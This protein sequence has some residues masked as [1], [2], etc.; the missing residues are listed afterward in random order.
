MGFGFVEV[1]TIT[2]QPQ[3]GNPK[4]RVFRLPA[5]HALINRMGFNN[6]GVASAVH[7]F[8]RRNRLRP[9]RRSVILGVNLG[10]NTLTP[11]EKAAADY[12][13]LFRSLYEYVNYFVINVSC[14][15]IANLACLQNKDNLKELLQGLID[16]RRGQIQYRPIL[17]KI[18]PDLSQEQ[19][20]EMIEVLI[21]NGLDGIV[22]T[23]TTTRRDGLQT[24]ADLVAEIGKGGMSGGPLTKRSLEMVRYIHEKTEGRFPI[25]GVGGIMTEDDAIAMLDAG[26]SLIEIYTGFIYNSPGFVKRICKRLKE[27]ALRK[28]QA[29]LQAEKAQKAAESTTD[30]NKKD[31]EQ[32]TDSDRSRTETADT[33][34]SSSR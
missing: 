32:P 18:S 4:P 10:K 16:F 22:A 8:Y 23:N 9:N 6:Q 13:R 24:P 29:A 20:D 25:I 34:Q 3:P 2:P 17:L 27:E 33:E 31:V 12:L 28:E 1:G 5:D 11:N 14:P 15:N 26:A 21:E 7:R 19:V 30:Q